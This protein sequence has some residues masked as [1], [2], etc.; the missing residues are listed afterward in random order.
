PVGELVR[1]PLGEVSYSQEPHRLVDTR[2]HLRPWDGEVLEPEG[3]V[4]LDREHEYLVLGVLEEEAYVLRERA[5][6]GLGDL[7]APDRDAPLVVSR[8]HVG[9]QPVD[10]PEER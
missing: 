5:H 6:R 8:E 2:P 10:A 7:Q 9:D 4:P 1:G 3:D